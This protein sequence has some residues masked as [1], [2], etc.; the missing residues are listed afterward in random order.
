MLYRSVAITII[1]LLVFKGAASL[2][3]FNS[4]FL[5]EAAFASMLITY[6]ED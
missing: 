2:I 6:L 4:F 5:L 3:G 1:A